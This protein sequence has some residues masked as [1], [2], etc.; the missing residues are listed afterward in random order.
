MSKNLFHSEEVMEE[1]LSSLLT[2]D[3][4]LNQEPVAKLLE[5]VNEKQAE[6]EIQAKV[7]VKDADAEKEL[8]AENVLGQDLVAQQQS[9]KVV[10]KEYRQGEF[11]ALLFKVSG[12][13]VAVPL[14]EL[15][16][17]HNMTKLNS[18]FGKPD[19]FMGVMVNREEQLNVVNSAKW[20]MP[21]KYDEKLEESLNYQYLI[22]LGSSSWGL[23]CESLTNTVVLNQ[24]DV[25]WRDSD[26]KRPWLAGLVKDK[27]CALLD[28]DNLIQLLE[29]GLDSHSGKE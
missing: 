19:W 27:M 18:L 13:T 11:Q 21:E 5:Q 25:K 7:T 16:G 17:I 4:H 1:Y 6:S 10:E 22:M 24:D 14:M 8:T 26:G 12:L 28:V 2:E 15:G 9:N 3:K 20:I 23:A 29:K